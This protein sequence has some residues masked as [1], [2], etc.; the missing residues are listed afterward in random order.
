[1]N[2]TN[3]LGAL[4]LVPTPLRSLITCHACGQLAATKNASC[5]V[6]SAEGLFTN[7]VLV[8]RPLSNRSYFDD[9]YEV[10]Q[11][12]NHAEGTWDIF[13]KEQVSFLERNLKAGEVVVD[14]GCGPELPYS[15]QDCLVIGVDASFESI[16][17]NRDVDLRVFASADRL[18]VIDHAVDTIVCFYSV[19]HMTGSTVA[20]NQSIVAGVFHEF[21]RVLKPAGRL[22]IFDVSPRWP[23]ATLENIFWNT[24]RNKLGSALDMFF[25]KDRALC[26]VGL[27]AMPSAKFS[28]QSFGA[29]F[30]QTFP[31]IFSQPNLRVPRMLYPF[32]INLYVW[33]LQG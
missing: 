12:G 15:K 8:A 27:Q 17:A 33:Q 1:M 2:L 7:E 23:F 5:A 10:M 11:V 22:M 19:H 13:Y 14:I 26:Q 25:W 29:S 18:P 6:C 32:D 16:R 3:V 24:G 20:E 31:P 28:Q 9:V 21:S 30:F 4:D